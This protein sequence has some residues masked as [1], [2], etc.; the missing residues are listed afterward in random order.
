VIASRCAKGGWHRPLRSA[1]R[2]GVLEKVTSARQRN[3]GA[4]RCARASPAIPQGHIGQ[5]N[6]E[7]GPLP[8]S[9]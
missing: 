7:D 9:R 2:S 6:G 8:S 3:G 1:A 5:P 4:R